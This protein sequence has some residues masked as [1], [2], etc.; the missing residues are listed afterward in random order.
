MQSLGTKVYFLKRYTAPVTAFVPFFGTKNKKKCN[1]FLG[2]ACHPCT[3]LFQKMWTGDIKLQKMLSLFPE[4]LLY[5]FELFVSFGAQQ[6]R[7]L[8]LRKEQ[9][10]HLARFYFYPPWKKLIQVFGKT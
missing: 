10:Q 7:S 3:P 5:L 4:H 9:N 8:S 6:P 1:S 2:L